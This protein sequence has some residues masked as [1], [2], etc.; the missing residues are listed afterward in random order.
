MSRKHSVIKDDLKIV[1]SG[2]YCFLPFDRLDKHQKGIFKV[3]YTTVTINSRADDY[4]CYFPLGVYVVATLENPSAQGIV[5][6]G[7]TKDMFYRKLED[8]LFR[9]LE[10]YGAKRIESTARVMRQR[11]SEW[12]YTNLSVIEKAFRVIEK[13][14]GGTLQ[15]FNLNKIDKNSDAVTRQNHFTGKIYY[16]I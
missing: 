6:N 13:E 16:P 8:Q 14:Y 10:S 11:K 2:L 1:G 5:R 15:L 12:F 3:G 4:H 9:L 7:Y